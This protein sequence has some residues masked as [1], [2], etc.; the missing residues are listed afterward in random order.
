MPV[1][2]PVNVQVDRQVNVTFSERQYHP[3][4]VMVAYEITD[5]RNYALGALH[6]TI[7]DRWYI[8]AQTGIVVTDIRKYEASLKGEQA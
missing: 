5:Q 8:D 3:V 4:A 6:E 1:P 7:Q 2:H